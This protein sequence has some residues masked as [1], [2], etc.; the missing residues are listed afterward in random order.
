MRSGNMSEMNQTDHTLVF[1]EKL[2]VTNAEKYKGIFF[3]ELAALPEDTTIICDVENTEYISSAGLRLVLL[4]KKRFKDTVFINVGDVIYDIF[5]STG[6]TELLDVKRKPKK[7]EPITTAP[8][9]RGSNGEVYVI[10]NDIIV[11]MFSA[12]TTIEEI[13]EEWKNAKTAF[14]LG[15]PSVLCY[16]MV[17]DG[18]RFGTMFERMKTASLA[19][20]IYGDYEHFDDYAKRFAGLLKEMHSIRDK[21]HDLHKVNDGFLSLVERADHLTEDEI[22]RMMEFLKAVPEREN[23]VHGDFHPNNIGENMGE[24]ILLDLAEIGYGHPLFDFIASY[25]DLILSGETVGVEHPEVTKQFFG[26]SVEELRKLWDILV[27]NYFPGITEEKKK[28]F[29]ETIDWMLGFKLLL[30]PVLHPNHP[31]EKHEAWIKL[32]RERFIDHYEEV[33]SRIEEID[34][35]I[36]NSLS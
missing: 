35:M 19:T 4:I 31:K 29:N 28:F 36:E 1:P 5:E 6:M 13:H 23:V 33:M 21:K 17:T 32:G 10:E 9:A 14:V 12:K 22:N 11:K 27:E 25:Y 7:I 8:L 30:F 18:E 20:V 15:V 24:L 2:D 34:K 3:T 16:A 26:L